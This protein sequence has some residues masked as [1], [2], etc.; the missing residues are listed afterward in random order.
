MQIARFTLKEKTIKRYKLQAVFEVPNSVG[1]PQKWPSVDYGASQYQ[2][3]EHRKHEN[4]AT[5]KM[6]MRAGN[7]PPAFKEYKAIVLVC[8]RCLAP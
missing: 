7:A 3:K 5:L 4:K 8:Q 6:E 2:Q 1:Y